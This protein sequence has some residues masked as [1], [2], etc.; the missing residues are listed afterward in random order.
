MKRARGPSPKMNTAAALPPEWERSRSLRALLEEVGR[1]PLLPEAETLKLARAGTP[2][3]HAK[4]VAHNLRLVIALAKSQLGA[5]GGHLDDL[6]AVG[7]R[8]LLEGIQ[9]FD[10][11]RGVKLGTYCAWWIRA[12]QL[13]Y[14][15]ENVSVVR[16]G[17]TQG[18]RTAFWNLH[19]EAGVLRA[20]GIDPSPE[21]L[22][23]ALNAR[24]TKPVRVT[25]VIAA[26]RALAGDGRLDAQL[27]ENHQGTS[28]PLTRLSLLTDN[29]PPVDELV[30]DHEMHA[31]AR[32]VF[33]RVRRS[34]PVRERAIF[35]ARIA[36]T[37]PASLGE[38]GVRLGLSRERVR[39]LEVRIRRKLLAA[40][41]RHF[42]A[43]I[44][45]ERPQTT[46]GRR[47][48]GRPSGRARRV[49]VGA[50]RPTMTTTPAFARGGAT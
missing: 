2:A 22:T 10:P 46:R 20:Q 30:G 40:G 41:R 31:A 34:L 32:A 8:G 27:P 28:E 38:L 9:R 12:Y 37:K 23:A 35:D 48:C 39:Q 44:P 19:H 15:L 6:V 43:E 17:Q 33:K 24:G 45:E 21:N 11:D 26:Q 7:C 50:I 16:V 36:E 18:Q 5:R 49:S 42:R 1:H 13:R 4:L 25:D 29:A 14:M 3:A 47:H